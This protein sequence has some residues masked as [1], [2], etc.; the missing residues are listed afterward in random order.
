MTGVDR[1]VGVGHRYHRRVATGRSGPRSAGDVL[2]P[3][4]AGLTKV[5]VEIDQTR[6]DP[7]SGG[8]DRVLRVERTAERRNAVIGDQYIGFDEAI[9][10]QHTAIPD[11]D[12]VLL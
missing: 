3:F 10:G 8:I 1:R 2:F 6:P 12:P 11:G 7:G 4:L 5:D 9:W